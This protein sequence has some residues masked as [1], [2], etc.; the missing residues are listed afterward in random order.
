MKLSKS[1]LILSSAGISLTILVGEGGDP[2]S[3]PTKAQQVLRQKMVELNGGA[4]PSAATAP[5]ATTPPNKVELLTEVQRLH[6]EGKITDQQLETFRKNINEQYAGP[7]RS[8][9]AEGLTQAPPAAKPTPAQ[10]KATEKIAAVPAPEPQAKAQPAPQPQQKP[11]PALVQKPSTPVQNAAPAPQKPA[12][13]QPEKKA[14]V[15]KAPEPNPKVAEAK[16]VEKTP[17]VQPGATAGTLT[18]ELEA[19]ARELLRAQIAAGAKQEKVEP[20]ASAPDPDAQAKALAALRQQEAAARPTPVPQP[21]TKP[22]PAPKPAPPAQTAPVVVAKAP[23]PVAPRATPQPV[24]APPAATPPAVQP[25]A[26]PA[27][28]QQELEAKAGIGPDTP[29]LTKVLRARV[30]E[31]QG[32]LPPGQAEQ[33]IAP[34]VAPPSLPDSNKEGSERLAE[35]TDLYKANRITPAQYHQERAKIVATLNN[36]R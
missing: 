6:Q 23:E 15:Q 21:A 28:P 29:D 34:L 24:A 10:P 19:K 5:V 12:T 7:A 17:T 31:L 14:V 18:P 26:A 32:T 25:K 22:A 11:A 33:I 9:N 4:A 36:K 30:A 27:A 20:V 8:I 2:N 3:A 35:L 1:L 16:P 13:P